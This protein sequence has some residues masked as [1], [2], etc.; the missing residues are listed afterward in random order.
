MARSKSTTCVCG[1]GGPAHEHYRRGSDC[2]LCGPR[3]CTRFRSSSGLLGMVRRRRA[4]PAADG[5]TNV[6]D[7]E[8]I[9][10]HV[11]DDRRRIVETL[12]TRAESTANVQYGSGEVPRK[13]G[14]GQL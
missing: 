10:L 12:P 5:P 3:E 14:A 8:S 13:F 4:W 2:S 1:H 6:V 11:S 9:A 7:Q